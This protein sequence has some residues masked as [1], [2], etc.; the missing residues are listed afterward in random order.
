MEAKM[1]RHLAH[2]A[3]PVGESRPL[4]AIGYITTL[5]K[6]RGLDAS[7]PVPSFPPSGGGLAE[8]ERQCAEVGRGIRDA[9]TQQKPSLLEPSN[10]ASSNV[11]EKGE[12]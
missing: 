1:V 6:E 5:K 9:R 4:Y 3:M 8:Y 2:L 12:V 7:H 10:S 11:A